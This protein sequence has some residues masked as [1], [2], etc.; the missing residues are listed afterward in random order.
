[1]N[2]KNVIC[3]GKNTARHGLG[4]FLG[5]FGGDEVKAVK[6]VQDATQNLANQGKISGKFHEGIP[7]TVNGYTLT[8]QGEV[9]DGTAKIGTFFLR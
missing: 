4:N 9:V 3:Y 7:V 8:V 5:S 6:A 1:M 2:V